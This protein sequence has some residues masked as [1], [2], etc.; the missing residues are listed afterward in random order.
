MRRAILIAVACLGVWMPSARAVDLSLKS[1]LTETLEFN[2]N[3]K[4]Q[5][6]S[7]GN[8][9]NS[10]SALVFDAHALTPTSRL[11]VIGGLT[12]NTY[13][14]PGEA[15]TLNTL[16]NNVSA[17]FEKTT[18][19]TTY[20]LNA[21]RSER[22]TSTIQLEE[23]GVATLSGS[24]IVE[25]IGGGFKHRL[26][27][28]D[29][30]TSQTTF[31]STSFTTPTGTPTTSLTSSLSWI[32]K[33]NPITDLL[34]SLQYQHLSYDNAA[35][36]EVTFWQ[37]K[38]AM[39]TQLTKRLR[40]NGSFGG[41]W[42]DAKQNNIAAADP[43]APTSGSAMDWIADMHLTYRPTQT[44]TVGLTA[45]RSIGPTTFGQ[46]QKTESFS[47]SLQYAINQASSVSLSG[48]FSR[49][50]SAT[51]SAAETLSASVAYS[52][53]LAREWRSQIS[54]RFQQR[55]SATSSAH[56][57][58]VMFSVTRDATILP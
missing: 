28:R 22:D 16:N 45:A 57:N 29:T 23:T 46:F 13:A 40:F 44:V 4:M 19:L 7:A 53:R 14:G 25:T 15:N 47:G 18:K 35:Q 51:A 50:A 10:V 31:S 39:Q 37:A 1:S 6:N 9:Y 27:P 21:S 30:V 48:S 41:V 3:R 5:P 58:A 49:Q 55:D 11:D 43:T 17:R 34:P 2:N 32:H 12:Y 54:Y 56:S 26:G 24:T 8:S 20:N 38:M 33:V 36:S 42:L 52:R